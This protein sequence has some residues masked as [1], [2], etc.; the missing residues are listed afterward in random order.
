MSKLAAA[1]A[2]AARGF[3]VF[4][5]IPNGKTPLYEGA[6]Y[7]YATTNED[8]IRAYWLDPVLK[9]EHDYNI[10]VD[11]SDMVVVDIDVKEG[12]DGY[13]QYRQLGGTFDTLVVK[14]PTGG[15]HCYFEGPASANVNIAKDIEIRSH[16]GYVVA[17]GST[18]DG[19]P[20]EITNNVAPNWIPLAVD[21]L[22][23]SVYKRGTDNHIEIDTP[24]NIQAGINFLET[25]PPAIEGQRGDET[26]F[27]TAARLVRE[28]G[29]STWTAFELMR[30]Y[31]NPRCSPPWQLDELLRKVENAA[32][33]G[34]A[35][36]GSLDPSVLFRG[37]AVPPPPPILGMGWGNA[38]DPGSIRERPWLIERVLMRENTSIIGAAGAAGK[39]S[40]GLV[41]AAH[42]V[43]GKDFAGYKT[44]Y[45]CKV[46]I[47]N[48]EDDTE[49]Q[50]RRLLAVCQAYNFDY[51]TVKNRIMFI[52]FED[53]DLNLAYRDS[54]KV[55]RNENLI[56]QFIDILRDPDIGLVILD[57]LVDTHSLREDDSSDM[58]TVMAIIRRIAKEGN[59]A[60][61]LMHHTRKGGASDDKIGNMETFRGSSGI[62]Y[63]CR[64]A[65]TLSDATERDAEDYGLT[66]EARHMWVRMDD[67]KMQFTLKSKD[68]VWFRKVGIKIASG[69]VVGTLHHELLTRNV[70]FMRVRLAE[71]LA[72][73][74]ILANTASMTITQAIT[75]IRHGEPLLANKKDVEIRERIEAFAM[76][77]KVGERSVWLHREPPK[78]PGGSEK[79]AI[80]LR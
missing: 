8:A 79:I 47:Y 5:L 66:D 7:D 17:P 65:F 41:I 6:W 3:P 28:I 68:T 72:Q 15:F 12:K 9:T 53:V 18:I 61:L 54:G 48:G 20:Y 23:T 58:N 69:D 73:Q 45:A 76:G 35:D 42:V 29:L 14:T 25:C 21:R 13:N 37:A 33:Y 44:R 59:V 60:A 39:S 46:A 2:W 40:L 50:S 4:P 56:K 31:F 26:T 43:L 62:V 63:K 67:A 16:H 22:L 19:K 11:C 10:G 78:T 24:A 30:D 71:L 1:L 70:N 77:V 55:V 51:V 74:M 75:L 32:Q 34:T 80:V 27:I 64:V 38:L 49:E 52:S 57:P 36:L